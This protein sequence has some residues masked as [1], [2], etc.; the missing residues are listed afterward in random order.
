MDMDDSDHTAVKSIKDL[1]G[2]L[3]SRKASLLVIAGTSA[4][5]MFRVHDLNPMIIGR[6]KECDI[7]LV[8]DG[9][10]R[11]HARVERDGHGNI[12]IVDLNS[13]NGTHHDGARI[14]RHLMRDGDLIQVGST[15]FLKFSFQASLEES[16]HQVQYDQ[17]IRDG[18]TGIF[19]KRHFWTK[20]IEEFA[21]SLRHN[22]ATSLVMVDI[23]HFKQINDTYGHLAGDMVLRQITETI[24]KTL[25]KEDIFARYG[26]EEFAI[27]LRNQDEQRAYLAAERIRRMVETRRFIWY[28]TPIPITVSLGI[29][30]MNE[31]N[32]LDPEE[33]VRKADE[34]LYMSK[35]NGR[36]RTS[37]ETVQK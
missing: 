1:T 23:D 20:F 37:C 6:S 14:T 29:A 15:T 19:N 33:M 22:E 24:S 17:A 21:Y 7:C 13:T 28:G 36:N 9:I 12:I 30:T 26:G 8:E 16:F 2:D 4:G 18:L 5:K 27:I 10:S 35:E 32:F 25:R 34:Y 3:A 31:R 11:Q